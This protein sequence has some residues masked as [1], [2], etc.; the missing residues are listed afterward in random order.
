MILT[1]QK[2]QTQELQRNVLALHWIGLK[3]HLN[4]VLPGVVVDPMLLTCRTRKKF[5]VDFGHFFLRLFYKSLPV[6]KQCFYIFFVFTCVNFTIAQKETFI[7]GSIHDTELEKQAGSFYEPP[8]NY[9]SLVVSTMAVK[10]SLQRSDKA[11]SLFTWLASKA[12]IPS[13]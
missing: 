4:F 6:Y 8:L 1:L 2:R 9:L 5:P 7:T 12:T 10:K 3:F 11:I 13:G